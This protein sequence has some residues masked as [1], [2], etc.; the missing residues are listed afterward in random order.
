M[1]TAVLN[2]E[3]GKPSRGEIWVE[4]HCSIQY[5]GAK[6]GRAGAGFP[7]TAGEAI[8]VRSEEPQGFSL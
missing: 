7:L 8:T 4:C 1:P 3:K 6:K 5:L 2:K